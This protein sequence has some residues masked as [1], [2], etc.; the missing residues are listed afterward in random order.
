M[1]RL[2]H[3]SH[4]AAPKQRPL[5]VAEHGE[6]RALEQ[7][8]SGVRLVETCEQ[9]QKGRFADPGLAHDRDIGAWL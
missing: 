2:E 8:P 5:I 3:E 1:E 9:V 6:I 7:H 4:R